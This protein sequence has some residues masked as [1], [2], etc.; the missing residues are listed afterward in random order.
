MNIGLGSDLFKSGQNL[1][2]LMRL[3]N[4]ERTAPSRGKCAGKSGDTEPIRIGFKN[5]K[6][7]KRF[8][9]LCNPA[10]VTHKRI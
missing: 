1:K 4:A 5:S 8:Y 10:V 7:I 6:N 3:C 2:R 9:M